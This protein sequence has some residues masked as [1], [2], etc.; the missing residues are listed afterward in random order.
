MS[1][2][3]QQTL[4]KHK[5]RNLSILFSLMT[6]PS[7]PM[8]LKKCLPIKCNNFC[9]K[10]LELSSPKLMEKF[11][12]EPPSYY[13]P[14]LPSQLLTISGIQTKNIY[15]PAS[16]STQVNQAHCRTHTK[17]KKYSAPS[18]SKKAERTNP[19]STTL[20][21]FSPNLSPNHSSSP[22]NLTSEV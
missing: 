22:S 7:S 2:K 21:S 9:T 15:I 20:C 4:D 17:L 1:Q 6:K 18:S 3:I 13:P 10:T 14:T 19:T 5:Y 11:V 16:I 12:K 8:N